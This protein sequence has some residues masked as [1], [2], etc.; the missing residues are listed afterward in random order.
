MFILFN[1]YLFSER[2]RKGDEVVEQVPY[3][4]NEKSILCKKNF[5][6]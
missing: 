6:L 5:G 1:I 2:Q 3:M 4:K